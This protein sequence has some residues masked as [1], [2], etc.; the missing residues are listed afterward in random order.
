MTS[1]IITANVEYNGL[2]SRGSCSTG[3]NVNFKEQVSAEII[4]GIYCLTDAR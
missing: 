1:Q 4:I 3:Q 2:Q